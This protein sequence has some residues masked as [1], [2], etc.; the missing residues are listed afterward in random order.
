MKSIFFFICP[1]L[2][3]LIHPIS[4]T[5]Q[6]EVFDSLQQVLLMSDGDEKIQV[7]CEMAIEILYDDPEKSLEYARQAE[8]LALK[9]KTGLLLSD[10]LK[11]QGDALYELDSLKQATF[12]Y[13]K[14]LEIEE[15]LPKP[16]P[17]IMISRLSDVGFC[18]Q[19]MGL[20]EK[21]LDYFQRS[22]AL[23]RSVRDTTEI[24]SN[25]SNIGVSLK[26]LGKYGEAIDAFNQTLKLDKLLGSETDMATDYNNIGMVYRAWLQ[27]ELAVEFFEKALEID[28]RLGNRHKLSTRYS[29]IGQVYLAWDSTSRS[30]SY[31]NKALEI[32][33]EMNAV[34]KIA[35]RLHGL[36]LSYMSLKDYKKAIEYLNEAQQIFQNLN[37]DFQT[38]IV[39]EHTG[40][41]YMAMNNYKNA[42]S[43]YH[44]S[45]DISQKIGLKPTVIE[46]ARG[47][48]SLYKKQGSYKKSLEYFEIFKVAEDSVFSETSARQINEFEIR[49]ETEKKENQNRL[50][51]K[52]VQLLKKDIKLK[53]RN[54][55]LMGT[56]IVALVL[57]SVA[58]LYAFSLKRKSLMQS[59]VLFEKESELNKLKI[60]RVEKQNRHLQ[61]VLFA[62]EEI[63]RLQKQSIEQKN[64][65]LT[66]A[67]ILIA[68]KNEVLDKLGKLAG[69][70]DCQNGNNQP[71]IR[72]EMLHEIERQTDVENQWEQF[73]I[74]FESIHKS[75]FSSLHQNNHGLTQS[76]LQLCAYIKLNMGTK[77]IARLMNIAPESVN[78]HRY[79][80]RKKLAL[81][82]EET[83]DGFIHGL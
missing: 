61:E 83:L 49:Y 1:L 66:S 18:Y 20:F 64:H 48:Y 31:L 8:V 17:V 46:A 10:A 11:I 33:R 63:K 60:D 76:D 9:S 19:D 78:T 16:R 51:T 57:I 79:R 15:T 62:E 70:M 29:N 38:A 32:D 28:L 3:F 55:W 45:L 6:K 72:R 7:L 73:K 56:L 74:H 71:E 2:F 34:G 44:Q 30:I 77:E 47:L 12:A 40:D 43:Y 41:A 67:A 58:L 75:F 24:A 23:S 53:N 50:L 81:P 65:E 22:L 68:N 27:F 4:A 52:D 14:A 59:R 39:M 54:Q 82:A 35:V 42:E 13:M 26:M 5:S 69:K 25:L 36:G 37:L 80:L 21:S